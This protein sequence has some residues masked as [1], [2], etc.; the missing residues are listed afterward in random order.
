MAGDAVKEMMA[1]LK[2][3]GARYVRFELPDL[4]G[5]SRTKVIPVAKAESYA[6]KGLNMYGG[7]IGLDSA[8]NVIGGSGV[9]EE[10]NYR[11]QMLIPD[12]STLRPVPW[13]EDTAKVICDAYWAPGEPVGGTPRTVLASVLKRA[14]KLGYDVMM[15]LEFEFYLLDP[16]TKEPLF[17]GVHIFN[18]T[19]NQY[20]PFLDVILDLLEEAGI[21]VIT[22]NCEYAPSQFEINFGPGIGLEGAD[23]A[24]T[25]KNAIKELAHR[26]GYLATFMLYGWVRGTRVYDYA[27]NENNRNPITDT[28]QTLTLGPDGKPIDVV[29]EQD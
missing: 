2:K 8:S 20:V 14:E 15:G 4:H 3:M 27:C 12:V 25:F 13:L 10:V 7:T 17:G 1:A 24:F 21:D 16:E 19:R 28:G 11:D 9:H 29:I 18:V 23:K 26:S 22:H 5:T 6:R